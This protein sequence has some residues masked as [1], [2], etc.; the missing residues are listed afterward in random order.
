MYSKK[1]RLINI[2][3]EYYNPIHEGLLNKICHLAYFNVGE[4]GW[5]LFRDSDWFDSA[6]KVHTSVVKDIEYIDDQVIVTTLNTKY[7]FEL[8][9]EEE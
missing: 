4:R 8:I 6:D 7:V 3:T 2:I 1:Y 5:F 9:K